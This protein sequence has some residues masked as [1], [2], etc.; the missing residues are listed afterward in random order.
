MC[1]SNIASSIRNVAAFAVICIF[2]A[3]GSMAALA[4]D[5]HDQVLYTQVRVKCEGVGGSG[6][7]IYSEKVG[8]FFNTYIITC[9]H[10][11]ETAIK[12]EKKWNPMLGVDRKKESRSEITVE[13]FNYNVPHG[14]P[15]QTAGTQAEL[16]AYDVDHDMAL[17]RVKLAERPSVARLFPSDRT[18][19]VVIGSPVVAVGC[20]LLHDP[21]L[22]TGI[23]THMGTVI[24][25]K[26]YWMSQAQI[27]YGNSGGGMFLK[28]NDGYYFLG[29]P[30]RIAVTFGTPITHMGFFSPI[31]RVYEFFQEQ[32]FDFLIPGSTKT[33][34][35]CRKLREAARSLEDRKAM[36]Q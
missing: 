2:A 10:V 17:L 15:P 7:V 30:S 21:V 29:V 4:G 31:T 5:L 19:E 18:K 1:K 25:Y 6:T 35:E 28:A 26:D 11:I 14:R 16:M 13:I 3:A 20:A 32:I 33:E 12:V 9:W 24:D 27:I 23:V 8:N 34:A 36:L 22:T